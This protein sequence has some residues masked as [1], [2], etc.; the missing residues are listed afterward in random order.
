[1]ADL[2]NGTY[3][4]VITV[5]HNDKTKEAQVVEFLVNQTGHRI[6]P[7]FPSDAIELGDIFIDKRKEISIPISNQGTEDWIIHKATIDNRTFRID[8]RFPL[9]IRKSSKDVNISLYTYPRQTGP[10]EAKLTLHTNKGEYVINITGNVFNP[11]VIQYPAETIHTDLSA[12]EEKTISFTLGNTGG[13][14]LNF[15]FPAFAAEQAVKNAP[16]SKKPTLQTPSAAPPKKGEKDKRRGSAVMLGAGFDNKHGYRWIDSDEPGGPEYTWNDISSE[17]T[18]LNLSDDTQRQL[19]LNFEFPFYGKNK[20]EITIS[21]NGQ[22]N[23]SGSYNY[24]NRSIPYTEGINNFI[25]FCWMDLI[26]SSGG[27]V[28]YKSTAEEF[29]VQYDNVQSYNNSNLKITCQAVLRPSGEILFYYK[30]VVG[31]FNNCTIGIENEDGTDGAQV[32]F[33]AHYLKSEHAVW[34]GMRESFIKSITPFKGTIATGESANIQVKV[35]SAEYPTGLYKNFV[36]L[37]S[38]SSNPAVIIPFDM[39]VDYPRVEIPQSINFGEIQN[40]TTKTEML[41][42]SNKGAVPCTIRL[43]NQSD[44]NYNEYF[45]LTWSGDRRLEANSAMEIPVRFNPPSYSVAGWLYLSFQAESE[46]GSSQQFIVEVSG[47]SRDL[48][49]FHLDQQSLEVSLNHG[50]T[51]SKVLRFSNNGTEN[52]QLRMPKLYWAEPASGEAESSAPSNATTTEHNPAVASGYDE[53]GYSWEKGAYDWI[54][55]SETGRL[56]TDFYSG[57]SEVRMPFNF[58]FYGS[59]KWRIYIGQYGFLTFNYQNDLDLSSGIPSE[60]GLNDV[61]AAFYDRFRYNDGKIYYQSTPDHFIVQYQEF[62]EESGQVKAYPST[63]QIILYPSGKIKFQYK[64]IHKRRWDR[65]IAGIENQDG[66]QGLLVFKNIPAWLKSESAIEIYPPAQ[67]V[68]APGES[69]TVSMMLNARELM[70]GRHEKTYPIYS[71]DPDNSTLD[72]PITLNITGQPEVSVTKET[73][74]FG[75]VLWY[76]TE[77]SILKTYEKGLQIKNEGT[78]T[79]NLTDVRFAAGS[80]FFVKQTD[81]PLEL[82]PNSETQLTLCFR[83]DGTIANYDESASLVYSE[84]QT[85]SIKLK[86]AAEAAPSIELNKS[87]VEWTAIN[88]KP[89]SETLQLK[90]TGKGTL[91]YRASLLKKEQITEKALDYFENEEKV[92]NC[93]IGTSPDEKPFSIATKFTA[94]SEGFRLTHV[95]NTYSKLYE[96]KISFGISII[97]GGDTPDQGTE[98][99]SQQFLD[100]KIAYFQTSQ[101]ALE[102]AQIFSENETFWVV[103]HYKALPWN[104]QMAANQFRLIPGTFFLITENENGEKSMKDLHLSGER[105]IPYLRALQIKEKESWL[106][107]SPLEGSAASGETL[108]MKLTANPGLAKNGSNSLIMTIESNDP[109]NPEI[110]IPVSLHRN[111]TPNIFNLNASTVLETETVEEAFYVNDPDGSD[112]EVTVKL[113]EEY[114]GLT[115]KKLSANSYRLIY[116]TD[117]ESSGEK[118]FVLMASDGNTNTREVSWPVNVIDKNRAPEVLK[119]KDLALKVDGSEAHYRISDYITDPDR[120]E[121]TVTAFADDKEKLGILFRDNEM[122]LYP[123]KSG[124]VRVTVI[125]TDGR[126]DKPL[127][128]EFGVSIANNQNPVL[129]KEVKD[130]HMKI[131]AEP[132]TVDLAA[133]FSDPDNDALK[134]KITLSSNNVN[135]AVTTDGKLIITPNKPGETT[136]SLLANDQ[137][138]GSVSDEFKV[139]VD[140]NLAPVISK[141]FEP[142]S[143][144]LSLNTSQSFELNEYFSDPEGLEL[145][146]NIHW[147]DKDNL[148][149]TIEEDH[150]LALNFREVNRSEVTV[151]ASDPYGHIISQTFEVNSKRVLNMGETSPDVTLSPNPV[152][153]ILTV[154]TQTELSGSFKLYGIG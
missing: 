150:I 61:I 110:N 79:V 52:L 87:S 116:S 4:G 140:E 65:H 45:E 55:I 131:Y 141:A 16:D 124:D 111:H 56:V 47:T 106:S 103:V 132:V 37:N 130:F 143:M 105:K 9:T 72:L 99:L 69:H 50:E 21:S 7:V 36:S 120:D 152:A 91:Q 92:H 11:P 74:D 33:N 22:L 121:I 101:I 63:L 154:K 41:R 17:G 39:A 104:P 38:N 14:P 30:D 1:G 117:Y 138:G 96:D 100:E 88:Q 136:V 128:T 107:F 151:T 97:R 40:G 32:A 62:F 24:E 6:I 64:K 60:N 129:A 135:A 54:D 70:D 145:S 26:P 122:I 149:A 34:F 48:P 44:I 146:Y 118:S 58:P 2:P 20:N 90:N 29:V 147:T 75:S 76:E 148:L 59:E 81:L 113:K 28:Y 46:G 77:A 115:L 93:F 137:R 78:K 109:L 42:I 142:L 13:Y 73:V 125:A 23:F 66:T 31:D 144:D 127:A 133:V 83:P 67:K 102:T 12:N 86:A 51:V 98:I 153:E 134:Y 119:F 15:S 27:K 139:T 18:E 85:A 43:T 68:L 80:H 84:Y 112:N 123:L 3:S 89:L 95:E 57:L 19:N 53:Y 8:R 108:N 126:V 82:L 49:K 114:K 25:A 35:N 5:E 10:V 94:P 71:N